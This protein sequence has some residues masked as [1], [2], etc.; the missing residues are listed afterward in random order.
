M[1]NLS[2]KWSSKFQFEVERGG[3]EKGGELNG[4]WV[5][6]FV[7]SWDRETT[8][9]AAF[10]QRRHV[11]L[12][13]RGVR[14]TLRLT[15]WRWKHRGGPHDQLVRGMF[16]RR[17][18]REPAPS[19]SDIRPSSDSHYAPFTSSRYIVF[20]LSLSLSLS[21]FPP[22]PLSSPFIFCHLLYLESFVLSSELKETRYETRILRYRNFIFA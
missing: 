9:V 4:E 12:I 11:P 10:L 7:R 5:T 1:A 2:S 13:P 8:V 15:G 3:R 16:T 19:S 22:R 21:L 18:H 20:P 6:W 17:L 14:S